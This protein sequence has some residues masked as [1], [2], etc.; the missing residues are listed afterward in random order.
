MLGTAASARRDGSMSKCTYRVCSVREYIDRSGSA[1]ESS[2][3]ESDG[4]IETSLR[5]S[6]LEEISIYSSAWSNVRDSSV[7][8]IGQ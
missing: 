2:V 3:H 8:E 7:S 4:S 5:N 1:G 6:S